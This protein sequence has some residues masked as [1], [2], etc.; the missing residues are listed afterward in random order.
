[1]RGVEGSNPSETTNSRSSTIVR[2]NLECFRPGGRGSDRTGKDGCWRWQYPSNYQKRADQRDY[3][4][5]VCSSNCRCVVGS[6]TTHYSNKC[7]G[8]GMAYVAYLKFAVNRH[9][10]SS[11]FL[12]TII[13]GGKNMITGIILSIFYGFIGY[14]I[15]YISGLDYIY[16][17]AAIAITIILNLFSVFEEVYES[18]TTYW[19]VVYKDNA[20]ETKA[21]I[22]SLGRKVSRDAPLAYFIANTEGS[23]PI[24]IVALSKKEYGYLHQMWE[25]AEDNS[26]DDREKF[27]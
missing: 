13:F 12:S 20:G 16:I 2:R 11:P 18:C 26:D 5:L 8:D 19:Y 21:L 4:Y 6:I 22:M 1:M 15:Y 24:S 23:T 25:H 7:S 9:E 14:G 27:A 3:P 10:G 17:L